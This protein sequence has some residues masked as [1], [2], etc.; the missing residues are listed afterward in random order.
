MLIAK[1]VE[2]DV[3]IA[4]GSLRQ[5]AAATIL[6]H[7][8]LK[9]SPTKS[10]R[11]FSG[12]FVSAQGIPWPIITKLQ[13]V[14]TVSNAIYCLFST[15]VASDENIKHKSGILVLGNTISSI[16]ISLPKI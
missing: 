1:I 15:M 5:E 11:R 9:I 4:R 7:E 6:T 3:L 13:L 12:C 16:C 2:Q 10:M 8:A 14:P